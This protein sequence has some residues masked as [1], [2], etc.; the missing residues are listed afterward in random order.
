MAD[1][2]RT[3]HCKRTVAQ[4][5]EPLA[6]YAHP[7]SNGNFGMGSWQKLAIK[8]LWHVTKPC[9]P[10]MLLSWRSLHW[11]ADRVHG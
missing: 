6:R 11:L 3:S 9:T 5:K 8:P 1:L 2:M 10:C 7:S 4:L